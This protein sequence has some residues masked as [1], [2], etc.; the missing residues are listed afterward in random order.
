MQDILIPDKISFE[1]KKKVFKDKG[2]NELHVVSDFDK[3]LTKAFDHGKKVGSAIAQ[4]RNNAYLSPEYTKEAFALFDRYNPIEINPCLSIDE[5]MPLMQE[6]WQK[7]L[8]LIVASG[9]KEDIIE[10]IVEKDYLPA[11]KGF[12]GFV[13]F[14]NQNKV[15]FLILSSGLGD[16]I[17]KFLEKKNLLSSNIHIISNFFD[18]DEKGFAKAYKGEIVHVFNKNES[19][20]KGTNY[21]E[22]IKERKHVLLLGDSLGDLKMVGQIPFNEIIKIAFLNEKIE[23]NF[24]EY[25]KNFD[26]IITNDA[27]LDFVNFLLKELFE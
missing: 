4:I 9:M 10:D 5:K 20:V 21:F 19:Q 11:R 15:P 17:K 16:I 6:W 8:K 1:K 2:I 12:D 26:V 27:S 3:T 18:F 13:S 24:E 14:L 22:K 7:H 23:E 25:K